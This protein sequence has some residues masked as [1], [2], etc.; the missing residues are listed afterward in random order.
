MWWPPTI[1]DT[2]ETTAVEPEPAPADAVKLAGGPVGFDQMVPASGN[3]FVSG[4]QFWFG[5]ARAG[6]V[7]RFWASTQVIRLSIGGARAKGV[8]TQLSVND[9][10]LLG[11]G[12]AVNAGP[13]PIPVH[14]G[15]GAVEVDRVMSPAGTFARSGKLLVGAAAQPEELKPFLV[16][17]AVTAEGETE[18]SF[19]SIVQR[20]GEGSVPITAPM[21]HATLAAG[22]ALL[23]GSASADRPHKR[24]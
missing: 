2:N 15:A 3:M 8:R 12:G 14:A 11:A 7:A 21:I 13:P 24:Q 9:L 17:G 19:I 6:L 22:R 23:R 1:A 10:A 16:H 20:R 4:R 18:G 5:P